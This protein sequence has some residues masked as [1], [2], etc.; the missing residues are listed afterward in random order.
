MARVAAICLA[1][2]LVGCG[3]SGEPTLTIGDGPEAQVETVVKQS[4]LRSDPENCRTLY[5]Q[6]FMEQVSGETDD[7]AVEECVESE[8]DPDNRP[9]ESVDLSD[10]AVRSRSATVTAAVNGGSFD[11]AT[12]EFKVVKTGDGWRIDRAVE[13]KLDRATIEQILREQIA[14]QGWSSSEVDCVVDVAREELSKSRLERVITGD[15]ELPEFDTKPLVACLSA[16]RLRAEAA[17]AMERIASESN[18]PQRVS[19]CV[20]AAASELALPQLRRMARDETG[21]VTRRTVER[22]VA[23]CAEAEARSSSS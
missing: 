5:T 20:V 18:L 9:A 13:A 4:L 17:E 21:V 15:A 10:L 19:E 1:M 14:E 3:S 12:F 22:L 2:L 7:A 23:R 6:G 11:G 16:E 8:A